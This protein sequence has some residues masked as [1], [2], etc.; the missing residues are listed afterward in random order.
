M[1]APLD[2]IPSDADVIEDGKKLSRRYYLWLYEVWLRVLSN[3]TASGSVSRPNLTAALS[4]LSLF[5]TTQA[6]LY[7]VTYY[8]RVTTLPG[9]SFSL[10]PT[11]TWRDGGVS[12]SQTFA[13]LTGAPGTLPTAFQSNQ[14][15]VMADSGTVIALSVAYA[16]VGSPAA[17]YALN[18]TVELVT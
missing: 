1:G 17:I 11:L 15:S 6:G 18:A 14:L 5:T 4:P 9:T 10:T 13:A 8:L 7:R 12:K 16:S 3:V 2:P